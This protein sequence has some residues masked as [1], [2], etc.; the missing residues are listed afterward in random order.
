M[1]VLAGLDQAIADMKAGVNDFTVDGKCSN[2]GQCCSNYLPVG[3]REIENI[4]RYI[5]KHNVKEVK[6]IFPSATPVVDMQCPFR[7]DV[8]RKC[9][10]YPVRPAICR[11]FQCDKPR[12]NIAA[13][14]AMYH[15]KFRAINMRAEFF[16]GETGLEGLL[17]ALFMGGPEDG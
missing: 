11:D 15:D 3:K 12:K 2:C 13:D 8:E 14:K 17:Q 10:I 1:S 5:K 16:N 6:R 7:S 9:L 4:K